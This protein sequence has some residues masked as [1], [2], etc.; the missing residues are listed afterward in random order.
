MSVRVRVYDMGKHVKDV[1]GSV[2]TH[3]TKIYQE[4]VGMKKLKEVFIN[5]DFEQL[6]RYPTV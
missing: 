4:L 6:D 2:R 3:T 5:Y 1:I